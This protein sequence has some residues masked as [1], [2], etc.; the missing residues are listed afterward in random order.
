VQK[1]KAGYVD[2]HSKERTERSGIIAKRINSKREF[3]DKGYLV[4][5]LEDLE[6]LMSRSE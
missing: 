1:D 2:G 3:K 5:D 4:Y 6:A